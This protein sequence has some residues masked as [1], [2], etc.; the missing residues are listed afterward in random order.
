MP[1]LHGVRGIAVGDKAR[2]SLPRTQ[3]GRTLWKRRRAKQEGINGIRD[4]DLKMQLLLRKERTSGRIFMTTV[5][6]EVEKQI[7]GSSIRI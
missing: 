4:H 3:K 1:F 7:V 2:T 5:E 6:L